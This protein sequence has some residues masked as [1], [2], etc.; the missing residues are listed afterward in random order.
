[1]PWSPVLALPDFSKPF[2]IETDA[3]KCGVGAVVM[4]QGHPIAY[5]SKA[6]GPKLRGVSTYEKEYIAILLA[7]E[8]WRSYLQLG[9][10]VIA[11]N[12]RSMSYLNEQRLHTH[13]QQK[14]FTKLL[15]LQ[16]IV[17]YKMGVENKVA[18]ALSRNP[19]HYR[20]VSEVV[21]PNSA[22]CYALSICQPKW[23]FDI[24]ES[25]VQDATAQEMIVKLMI[26]GVAVP[27]FSF[28]DGILRYKSR[29]WIGLDPALR[30]R[31]LVAC[32]SL[33][34]GGHSCVHVTYRRMKKLFAWHG[35][36]KAVHDFV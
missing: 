16:Y 12:H 4:Q 29:I 27:E 3:S 34:L 18:D 15:G 13:W 28:S 33:A 21:S 6:L 24:M 14:V 7:V 19:S 23:I 1:L 5:V 9:K 2:Q 20:S 32:H 8:Q 26:D 22:E 11:T 17:I 36:K 25:Y 31:L 35:M 30:E 10:F